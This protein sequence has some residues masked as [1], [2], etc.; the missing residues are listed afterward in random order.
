LNVEWREHWGFL[1]CHINLDSA[2]GL[3][4][5]EDYFRQQKELKD[6]RIREQIEQDRL[7]R[8]DM[9]ICQM[10]QHLQVSDER[11]VKIFE[12]NGVSVAPVANSCTVQ[13]W[14]P[15][16]VKVL[17]LDTRPNV[18]NSAMI[19]NDKP[20]ADG[21]ADSDILSV[22]SDDSFH[23]AADDIDLDYSDA[24]EWLD[25]NNDSLFIYGLTNIYFDI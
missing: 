2:D 16:Y 25:D 4:K 21:N 3:K 9:S 17:A 5:L 15:S 8:H 19:D 7:K 11:V 10:F 18:D 24:T 12:N 20:I 13:T 22:A 23:T 6:A 14:P 1:D